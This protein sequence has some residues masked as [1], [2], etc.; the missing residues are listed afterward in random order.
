MSEPDGPPTILSLIQKTTDYF[1]KN[2]VEAP[3]LEAELL[4]AKVLGVKRIQLYVDFGKIINKTELDAF[5]ELVRRRGRQEPVHYILGEREFW[6]LDFF[7]DKGVL[8]P[9]PD[10]ECL[11]EEALVIG[12]ALAKD[13]LKI[14]DIGTGSGI[15]AVVLGKELGADVVA[16]DISEK[17]LEVA[18]RN[19]ER[20]AITATF[21]HGDGLDALAPHGPFDLIATNPPY[22]RDADFVNLP[23]HVRLAE[24]R[25][26][27]TS[28]ADGLDVTRRIIAAL[29]PVTL[30]EGGALLIEIGDPDQAKVLATELGPRFA[31]VRTRLDYAGDARVVVA[32]GFRH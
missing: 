5:R 12:K 9:R 4:L 7:V 8:I 15:I 22:I 13:R 20:H 6:A 32:T 26:A 14:A 19:A 1:R 10:T 27:L 24:P 16:G 28:G 21:V 2:G 25:E 3:R 31:E 18:R 29:S 30:C 11:I 17:A 23:P